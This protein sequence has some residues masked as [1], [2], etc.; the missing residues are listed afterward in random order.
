MQY[1]SKVDEIIRQEQ[2]RAELEKEEAEKL[3]IACQAIFTNHD[4]FYFLKF[5]YRISLWAE[6]DTNINPEILIYKKARRDYWAILRNVIPKGVL[7]Q[8][9]IYGEEEGKKD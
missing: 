4:A 8:I 3:K 5:L 9:E 1:E 6:Q 2:A 7:A